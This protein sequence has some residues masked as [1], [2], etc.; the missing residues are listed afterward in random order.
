MSSIIWAPIVCGLI[1]GFIVGTRINTNMKGSVKLTAGA[2][3]VIFIAAIYMA[4]DMGQ[5]PYYTDLPISSAFISAIVGVL[6]GSLIFGR[7]IKG[8]N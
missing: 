2:L 6:F 1:I 5:M 7:S 4:Y 8:D 3:V